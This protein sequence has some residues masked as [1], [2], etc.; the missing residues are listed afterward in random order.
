MESLSIQ[1][2]NSVFMCISLGKE[3]V[4]A[5]I[6]SATTSCVPGSVDTRQ[7]DCNMGSEI[8]CYGNPK[9]SV[10]GRG[11]QMGYLINRNSPALASRQANPLLLRCYWESGGHCFTK[12]LEEILIFTNICTSTFLSE[13]GNLSQNFPLHEYSLSSGVILFLSCLDPASST[14]QRVIVNG[15]CL[16]SSSP[17]T[18]DDLCLLSLCTTHMGPASVWPLVLWL[19]FCVTE[20]S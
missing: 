11:I 7:S 19:L 1:F 8:C 4:I 9:Y 10:L 18:Q 15:L 16:L 3:N 2:A 12:V 14:S 6:N 13:P 17:C 20:Q 5:W